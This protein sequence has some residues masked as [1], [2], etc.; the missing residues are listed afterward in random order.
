ME[1]LKTLREQIDGI[2][3]DLLALFARRM[4][5]TQKVGEYKL[6]HGVQVLDPR[7]EQEVLDSKAALAPDA[8]QSEARTLFETIM[9]L[10]RRQQRRLVPASQGDYETYLAQKSQARTPVQDPRVLYQ[11]VPGAYAEE[12]AAAYFGEDCHRENLPSW[13]DVFAAL[14]QGKADYGVVPIEHSSTGSI[15]QVYDLLAK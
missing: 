6:A 11:G 10:S 13:E 9:A 3:R 14:R 2:D 5:V 8:I 12:A 4:E 15:N 1:D 7:R